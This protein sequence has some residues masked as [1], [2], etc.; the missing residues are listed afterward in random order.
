MKL[1]IP[2]FIVFCLFQHVSFGQHPDILAPIH[3]LF[4]GMRAGDRQMIEHAF[5]EGATLES[6]LSSEGT[7]K[8]QSSSAEDF[9]QAAG[10][11]H[12]QV[13]N[14]VIWSYDV[15]QDGPLATVW[16][17]Y[18]F[19]IGNQMSHCGVNAIQLIQSSGTWKITRITD[20]RRPANC[21][22]LE[23]TSTPESKIQDE[24]DAQ[25]WNPFKKA[26]KSFDAILMN[27]LH[28]NDFIRANKWGITVGEE[29]K[30]KNAKRYQESRE[31]GD[32]REIEFYF[33]SRKATDTH[34]VETGFYKVT[35]VRNGESREHFGYFN[36]ILKKEN[37]T[38]KITYDWDTDAINGEKINSDWISEK[39]K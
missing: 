31:R 23:K 37:D 35:S 5:A 1:S 7:S 15:K 16:T 29:Y 33:D 30:K 32:K 10:Q 39:M 8:I 28:S 9:I 3:S 4:D 20:T 25:V 14:E 26:Y 18:T 2:T 13:W 6:Y 19:Y 12:D 24:I 34:A 17:D 21:R 38:W 11:P 22:E 36:V 27:D